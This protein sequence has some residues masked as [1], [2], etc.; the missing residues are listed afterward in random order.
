MRIVEGKYS[1]VESIVAAIDKEWVS[2]YD[3]GD[4]TM[5]HSGRASWNNQVTNGVAELEL[6]LGDV[7]DTA[8]NM[9]EFLEECAVI[10]G[11]VEDM[12]MNGELMQ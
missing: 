9:V 8:R 4:P 10:V 3:V 1:I 7:L 6:R 12:L 2:L 5:K 11:E